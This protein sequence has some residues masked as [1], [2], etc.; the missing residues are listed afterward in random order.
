MAINTSADSRTMINGQFLFNKVIRDLRDQT[1]A[2]RVR[3]QFFRGTKAGQGGDKKRTKGTGAVRLYLPR[4]ERGDHFFKVSVSGDFQ[5]APQALPSLVDAVG[6]NAQYGGY[7][8]G[9]QV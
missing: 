4:V 1:I 9:G 5:T 6:G 2:V 7:L 3:L 8:P